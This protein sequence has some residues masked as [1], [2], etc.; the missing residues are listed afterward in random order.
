[1]KQ[2]TVRGVEDELH[3]LL[4]REAKRQGL[5]INRYVLSLLKQAVGLT[6]QKA[7]QKQAFDDLDH[8]AGTWSREEADEFDTALKQQRQIDGELWC[9]KR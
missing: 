6:E 7:T 9:M 5:S 1:M 4:Q 2:L 3:Q 8:L